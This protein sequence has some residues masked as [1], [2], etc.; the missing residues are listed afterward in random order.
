MTIGQAMGLAALLVDS[1]S[2]TLDTSL[3]LAEVL[4]V[5]R[6]YLYTWPER[7]LTLE[8]EASFQALMTRRQAGEPVAHLL[9]RREFWSLSLQVN[10]A[11]LIPRPDTELLVEVALAIIQAQERIEPFRVLDLGTGTGAIALAIASDC[12]RCAVLAVDWEA[13]AV[14]LAELN[15]QTLGLDNVQVQTSDWFAQVAGR[16][17]LI[18]SNPPYLDSADPHL[19]QGDVRFEPR[20]ALIAEEG[21]LADLKT[22]VCQA[23]DYLHPGG[24]LLLEHGYGQ[25]PAVR[26]L[27]ADAGFSGVRTHRDLAGHERVSGGQ[28][29]AP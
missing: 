9:R 21:G 26:A 29:H 5:D 17:S 4:K 3:L 1:E 10:N 27:L 24:F 8:Q 6:S 28:Y 25:G 16:F 20:S 14:A 12:P 22:I 2:A 11:T 13:G 7:V 18:V 23:P 19:A 15:R